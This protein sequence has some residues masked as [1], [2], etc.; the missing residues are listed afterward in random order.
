MAIGYAGTAT[1]IEWAGVVDLNRSTVV[2][3]SYGT[4]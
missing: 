3:V 1:E 4:T 2:G